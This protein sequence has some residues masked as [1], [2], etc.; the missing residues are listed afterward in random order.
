MWIRRIQRSKIPK[1][2]KITRKQS[3]YAA[4]MQTKLQF[5]ELALHSMFIPLPVPARLL[6]STTLDLLA[7]VETEVVEDA[8]FCRALRCCADEAGVPVDAPAFAV[9]G[10]DVV[11]VVRVDDIPVPALLEVVVDDGSPVRVGVD[12]FLS[13]SLLVLPEERFNTK[14][15]LSSKHP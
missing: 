3:K 14:Q 5:A 6:L 8:G 11:V 12:L 1:R 13:S 4:P 2:Q 15:C 7:V 9:L 10:R